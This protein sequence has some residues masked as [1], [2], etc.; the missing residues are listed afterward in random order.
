MKGTGLS[1]KSLRRSILEIAVP[2]SLQSLMQSSLSVIDQIMVGQLGTDSIAGIGL[3]GKFPGL[4]VITLSAVGVSASIMIS[5]Y[6]GAKDRHGIRASF[7]ANGALAMAMTFLFLL[8]SAL[9]PMQ[10]L[11]F[12]TTDE[13][14][15]AIGANYLRILSIGYVPL[16]LTTLFSAAL[17]NIGHVKAPMVAGGIAVVS[18]TMLNYVLI[19]GNFGAPKLGVEGT[20]IATTLSR[21]VEFFVIGALFVKA[22]KTS[23]YRV[24]LRERLPE[25]FM[26]KTV[27]IAA[28]IVMSEFLWGFGDTAYSAIYGHIG[29]NS[30]AAMSLTVPMQGVSIGLFTGLSTASGMLVGNVLGTGEYDGAYVMSGRFVKGCILGS[31]GV[32]VMLSFLARAYTGLFQ[33]PD[34]TRHS[35]TLVLYVFFAFLFVKVSNMVLSGGI[36]RSGGKTGYTLF[37]DLFGTWAVGVPLGLLA[38]LVFHLPVQWVY[39]LI[40]IEEAVRLILGL[41]VFRSKKWMQKLTAAPTG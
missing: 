24:S 38:A 10:I 6:Y 23:E 30:M 27:M 40:T 2:V 36:L 13:R 29:T 8:A 12:Y 11:H 33:V 25:G 3:G 28:P 34:A 37:I 41:I 17:R 31:M 21:G 1:E 4:F 32:G 18:N 16:M 14:V 26:K 22:Q 20:A 5:Q 7:L 39:F 15:A 35:T 9:F 19:F